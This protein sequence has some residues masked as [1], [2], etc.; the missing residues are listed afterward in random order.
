M[1]RYLVGFVLLWLF[2]YGIF[3]LFPYVSAGADVVY[4]AKI[5]QEFSGVVFSE[6]HPGKRVLIFGSSKVLA[7]FVPAYFDQPTTAA[8]SKYY[9]YNSG[10]PARSTFVPQLSEMVKRRTG[11]PDILLLTLPWNST[12]NHINLLHPALSD[13]DAAEAVFPFR[14]LIRD[15]VSFLLSAREHGGPLKYY[16]QAHANVE[17][18][19]DDRGYYFVSEQSRYQSD[20]L[21]DDFRLPSDEPAVVLNRSA[22]AGSA[23]LK[24]LNR[25]VEM[26]QIKCYFVP[27]YMREGEY[28][29]PPATD[30][31]FAELLRRNSSC[32]Q[33]GPDYY[34]YPNRM[35]SDRAHLNRDGA[36][37]YTKA[38]YEL[39]NHEADEER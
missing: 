34:L 5:H 4:R 37:V 21:P 3:R 25:I 32:K 15:F 23:E 1:A 19:I 17:R 39:L 33:L 20:S 24:E 36:R 7:G 30:I 9:S 11:V 31:A 2:F 26:H 12:A 29:P 38:I 22:D 8:V 28:A 14:Y 18:V 10:Y 6:D 13:H 16:R 27:Q 35:F